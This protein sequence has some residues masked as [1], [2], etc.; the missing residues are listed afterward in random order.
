MLKKSF[1]RPLRATLVFDFPTVARIASYLGD[2]LFDAGAAPDQEVPAEV[3]ST[4][5]GALD[6]LLSE[7]EQSS[8]EP[9]K[10]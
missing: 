6:A 3:E 2:E 9:D 4:G 7:I 8:D 1:G 10:A 5:D